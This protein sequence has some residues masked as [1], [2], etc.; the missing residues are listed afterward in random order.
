MEK[1]ETLKVPEELPVPERVVNEEGEVEER[2]GFVGAMQEL[3][4]IHI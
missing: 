4:L 3:S 1:K 2:N